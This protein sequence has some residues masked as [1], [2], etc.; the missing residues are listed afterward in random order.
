[1]VLDRDPFDGPVAEIAATK[2]AMTFVGGEL[3]YSRV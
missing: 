2:V 1:M 3:V